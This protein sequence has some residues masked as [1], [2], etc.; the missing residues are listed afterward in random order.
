M[1]GQGL[2]FIPLGRSIPNEW[3]AAWFAKFI[4]EVLAQ[5][6]VR[7]AIEGTGIT[8]SGQP[9]EVATIAA[10]ADIQNLLLQPY[11]VSSASAFLPNER[12]LDGENGVVSVSDGGAGGLITVGLFDGGVPFT[13]LGELD[14]L[15]V[16]GNPTN[17]FGP[18][19]R[20]SGT[21]PLDVLAVNAAGD[22]I[23]FKDPTTTRGATWV[24]ST[25]TI[26]TPVADVMVRC[27]TGGTIR[28]VTVLTAGGPGSCVVDIWKDSYA[29]F[30]PTVG[31]SICGASKPTI[32]ASIKYEDSTLTG[33]TTSISP[34]DVLVFHL[35]S[36]ST[37]SSIFIQLDIT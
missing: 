34:G 21:D 30:P 16:L 14:E 29:N 22:A 17:T 10:S 7:N 20:I 2:Q 11:V 25:G 33:W 13:K 24:I 12:V 9:G 5:A 37:F 23:E 8:I 18:V 6:D 35:D 28:K 3:D 1:P 4:R 26:A 27:Y 15:S 19:E 31:D 32:S 36:S